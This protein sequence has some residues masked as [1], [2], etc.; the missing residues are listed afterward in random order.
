MI[1]QYIF[2]FHWLISEVSF[3][4]F[5]VQDPA[6]S[7]SLLNHFESTLCSYPQVESNYHWPFK[8]ISA[9]PYAAALPVP[10]WQLFPSLHLQ[11]S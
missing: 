5:N 10:P 8:P 2:N 1:H 4:I 3:S 9:P 11:L 6:S 7:S